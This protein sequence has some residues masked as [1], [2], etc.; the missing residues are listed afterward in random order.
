MSLS[1][2]ADP[3]A[4]AASGKQGQATEHDRLETWNVPPSIVPR[5]GA[6]ALVDQFM[7]GL[8]FP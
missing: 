1:S 7:A 4:E 5:A 8:F 3:H 6:R 2:G